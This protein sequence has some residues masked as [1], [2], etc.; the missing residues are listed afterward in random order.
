MR[1]R[2]EL[3]QTLRRD[4]ASRPPWEDR[5]AVCIVR[6]GQYARPRRARRPLPYLLWLMLD[7]VWLRTLMGADI[8]PTIPC[9]P[10]LELPHGGRGVVVNGQARLGSNVRIYHRVTVGTAGYGTKAPTIGDSVLIGTGACVLG[11]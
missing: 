1:T 5:L 9:G 11:G 4:F 3:Q 10:G 6:L 7:R 8:A 2:A